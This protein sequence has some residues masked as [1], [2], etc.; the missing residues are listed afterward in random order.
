[1]TLIS[2]YLP[3]LCKCAAHIVG[4]RALRNIPSVPVTS[5]AR[6]CDVT[7]AAHYLQKVRCAWSMGKKG[8]TTNMK[9]WKEGGSKK[10]EIDR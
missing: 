6:P 8:G 3:L 2:H 7:P 1:M 10:A 9:V 4:K 5:L